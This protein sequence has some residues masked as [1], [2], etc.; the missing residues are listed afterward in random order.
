M[1][2]KRTSGRLGA[3]F[4]EGPKTRIGRKLDSLQKDVRGLAAIEFALIGGLMAIGLVNVADI[5]AFL[6]DKVQVNDAT[7]M[8]AQAVWA[9][10]DLNHLPAATKC[11]AMNSVAATAV[12]STSLGTAVAIQ[13]GFPLDAYYCPSTSGGLQYVSNYSSP[14]NNCSAAGNAGIAPGEF[15][16]VQ[17]TYSYT[18]I[19][20]GA[21]VVALLP[22]AIT[23]SSWVRLH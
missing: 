21:S 12:K 17:T 3:L 14:P 15:V 23:A 8:A 1:T 9:A 7:Q 19:L 22:S 16:K 5:S 20:P 11:P 2:G 18:P 4:R 6:F 10:C 13:N